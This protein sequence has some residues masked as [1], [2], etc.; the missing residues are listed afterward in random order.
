L[1]GLSSIGPDFFARGL[2]DD[3]RSGKGSRGLFPV[4]ALPMAAVVTEV[5][6]APG[7][8]AFKQPLDGGARVAAGAT[9]TLSELLP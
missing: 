7:V 1:L 5:L 6:P 9:K 8:P 4:E 2:L 3:V